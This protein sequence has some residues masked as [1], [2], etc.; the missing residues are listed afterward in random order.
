MII[1]ASRRTDIPACY[2]QWFVNRLKAGYVLVPNPRNPNR[3]SYIEVSP[4]N[5]DCIVFWTK[6]PI[7]MFDKFEYI[8]EL[9]YSYYVQFTLTPY[10]H[11]IEVGLPN[12]RVLIQGFIDL[13]EFLGANRVVWRYD[14]IILDENHSIAWHVSKF[15]TMCKKLH[16]HTQRCVISFFDSYKNSKYNYKELTNDEMCM[17]AKEFSA[18]ADKYGMKLSTCAEEIDLTE[19]GVEHGACIDKQLIEQ[20]IDTKITAKQ[21]ANQRVACGCIESIDIGVYDSCTNGCTYCYAT[22][23]TNNIN[24]IISRHYPNAPMISGYPNGNETITNRTRPS[25][26]IDQISFL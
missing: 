4:K 26:K 13:S 11:E 17:I 20:I 12:K 1:S 19:Y 18:I 10:E 8:S 23:N 6:N 15:E 5:V 14:P 16:N 24:R 21:D 25:Q 2:S 22:S 9:G 3:L 7:P